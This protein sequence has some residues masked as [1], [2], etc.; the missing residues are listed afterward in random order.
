MEQARGWATQSLFLMKAGT[1]ESLW[2]VNALYRRGILSCLQCRLFTVIWSPLMNTLAVFFPEL[3]GFRNTN[4]TLNFQL[5]LNW[6]NC[7][8]FRPEEPKPHPCHVF[9]MRKSTKPIHLEKKWLVGIFVDWVSGLCFSLCLW[10][11][12]SSTTGFL[13]G[14]LWQSNRLSYVD[15]KG[16]ITLDF[17]FLTNSYIG[18]PWLPHVQLSTWTL[19]SWNQ[20]LQAQVLSWA[21][22]RNG[23]AFGSDHKWFQSFSEDPGNK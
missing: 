6:P 15:K 12:H 8:S 19:V 20:L 13:S 11:G 4:S 21:L 14:P 17:I 18:L 23:S 5:H 2:R 9:P 3:L 1:L 16:N 7:S 10:G 22:S